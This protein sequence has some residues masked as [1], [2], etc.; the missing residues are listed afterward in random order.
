M[1]REAYLKQLIL[2][3]SGTVKDFAKKINMPYSTLH[4]ILNNVGGASVDKVIRICRGL[5]ITTDDLERATQDGVPSMF[6]PA[7]DSATKAALMGA[8]A[9][10]G[11]S[12]GMSIAAAI[13]KNPELLKLFKSLRNAHA[14]DIEEV[15]NYA[16][17][18]QSNKK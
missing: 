15:T 10:V 18:I 11:G 4:S 5:G 2:E 9:A 17:Y 14:D 8:G 1:T 12:L 13:A 6:T 16:K 7:I 3:D